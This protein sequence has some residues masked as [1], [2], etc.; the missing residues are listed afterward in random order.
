MGVSGVGAVSRQ[1][2]I[3]LNQ[4][5]RAEGQQ[6]AAQITQKAASYSKVSNFGTETKIGSSPFQQGNKTIVSIGEE[7]TARIMDKAKQPYTVSNFGTETKIGSSKFQQANK[8]SDQLGEQAT[9]KAM[10]EASAPIKRIAQQAYETAKQMKS[11]VGANV[12]FAA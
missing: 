5:V 12:N 4:G 3:P 6:V 8:Q 11:P 7:K 1:A 2:I 10:Q 9:S